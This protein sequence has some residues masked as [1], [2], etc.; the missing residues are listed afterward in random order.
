VIVTS[1]TSREKQCQIKLARAVH[2]GV[3][4]SAFRSRRAATTVAESS[5]SK[6]AWIFHLGN[7]I[8]NPVLFSQT[9]TEKGLPAFG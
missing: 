4:M 9:T 5:P 2:R 7:A 6:G 1:L 3:H 8:R